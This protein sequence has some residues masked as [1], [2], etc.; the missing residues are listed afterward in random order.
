MSCREVGCHTLT[1]PSLRLFPWM[2]HHETSRTHCCASTVGI[3][4]VITAINPM[5]SFICIDVMLTFVSRLQQRK[6]KTKRQRKKKKKRNVPVVKNEDHSSQAKSYPSVEKILDKSHKPEINQKMN[7]MTSKE[8][9]PVEVKDKEILTITSQRPTSP[10]HQRK[11]GKKT[12]ILTN[13][14]S[15]ARQD[16]RNERNHVRDDSTK[17]ITS[18]KPVKPRV[19]LSITMRKLMRQLRPRLLGTW[20]LLINGTKGI[21]KSSFHII[22]MLLPRKERFW[23]ILPLFCVMIDFSFLALSLV[24]KTIGRIIYYTLVLHKLAL[25][26]LKESDTAGFCY[27]VTCTYPQFSQSAMATFSFLPNGTEF[28]VWYVIVRWLCRPIKMVD[29]FAYRQK[30]QE[31]RTR[32]LQMMKRVRNGQGGNVTMRD[33]TNFVSDESKED[34]KYISGRVKMANHFLN[35]IRKLTP[36]QILLEGAVRGESLIMTLSGSERIL[37]GYCFV[38]LRSGYLFSPIVWISWTI[39]MTTILFFPLNAFW[40]HYLF[41]VGLASIRMSHYGASV[42]DLRA[43]PNSAKQLFNE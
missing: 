1:S 41:L 21:F 33:V 2:F 16:Q 43:R 3:I 34:N 17:K 11:P 4:R 40:G 8:D 37:L 42:D 6:T 38:V 9:R 35:V 32:T 18:P 36:L 26:E 28:V 31:R 22:I 29:T 13:T 5:N 12:H 10:I 39:Q 27:T 23:F 14:K 30:M 24:F 7:E 19:P 20:F 15:I 25:L